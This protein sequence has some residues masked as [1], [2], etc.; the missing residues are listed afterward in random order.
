LY[1]VNSAY[2]GTKRVA[3]H[4][5]I[6][7]EVDRGGL[8]VVS[9]GAAAKASVLFTHSPWILRRIS[10]TRLT[11]RLRI[12]VAHHPPADARGRLYYDPRTIERHAR[13]AFG[14]DF[15]WAPISPVCRAA[16]DA[17][18]LPFPR[19]RMDWT[20]LLFVDDW[21]A[22]RSRLLG[23]RPVIGRHS[24]P[25]NEKW[26]A[27]RDALFQV[28]PSGGDIQVKLMGLSEKMKE[29]IG[30][31]PSN[32]R[33]M[34]VNEIPVR[35]FLSAIDFFVYFHHPDWVE[36]YG[37]TV[38][39]AAAA[40]CVVIL[41]SYLRKTFGDAGLY[42]EPAEA[43]DLVRSVAADQ[44]H[45]AELSA[46]GR[47]IIDQRFGLTSYLDRLERV[48]AAARGDVQLD[49]IVERP[50]LA[51]PA[52]FQGEAKRASFYW[53]RARSKISKM[54]PKR[55]LKRRMKRVKRRLLD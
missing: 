15:V 7:A 32:W 45:F 34:E 13:R 20:N 16:F 50:R 42:C 1:H 31:H 41:P 47:A 36:A 6:M 11:A 35:E 46:R 10:P 33:T 18:G 22:V 19:L 53:Q 12:L 21:G 25:R 49:A 24:R 17:A 28:F 44:E 2:L 39:E 54:K 27:T 4:E 37:R 38:A 5:D 26:P 30:E 14:G 43:L 55:A 3:W 8:D 48:L 52:I 23:D 29:L 9:E 51:V 40:G